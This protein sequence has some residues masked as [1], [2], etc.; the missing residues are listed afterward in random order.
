MLA[1][2]T[3]VTY[4]LASEGPPFDYYGEDSRQR[5]YP[6]L[7]LRSQDDDTCSLLV[8]SACG[9]T[10]AMH[11]VKRGDGSGEDRQWIPLGPGAL[12]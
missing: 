4:Q 12:R 9:Y 1:P 11:G 5:Q 7:V 6:A 3:P 10:F 2:G 8:F